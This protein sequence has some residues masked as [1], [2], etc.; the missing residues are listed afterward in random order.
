MLVVI[1]IVLLIFVF[2]APIGIGVLAL[3]FAGEVGELVFWR[4]FLRRYRIQSGAEAMAGKAAVVNEACRPL[5]SVRF[6]GA[7]WSA[8]CPAGAGPGERVRI[9]EVDGLTLVVDPARGT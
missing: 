5:G 7:V 3:A 1:A 8:R 2:P 6:D 4:R 9:R